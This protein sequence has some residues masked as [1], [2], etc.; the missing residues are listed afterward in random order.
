M[1][2][3]SDTVKSTVHFCTKGQIIKPI[4]LM[5]G[6]GWLLPVAV[7][8][9]DVGAQI[10][11]AAM[12]R[13]QHQITYDGRYLA[14]DYPGGDVPANIGVCTD[15]VIRTYRAIGVDLQVLVHEDMQAAFTAYPNHWGNRK[16]DANIDHRRVPN[17][18]TFFT[19]HGQSFAVRQADETV[20]AGDLIT[21]M[22]P[23]NLPHI[24]VVT[25]QRHPV[26]GR[27]MMVH[28]VGS[29]PKLEDVVQAWLI[30]GHYRFLPN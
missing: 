26:S 15:V 27:L 2:F 4:I 16:P 14:L 17:L 10:S 22:L 8:A 13:T 19:R 7:M 21:W 6:F 29:G 23:G 1:N 25:D 30:T 18:Q 11:V 24:G 5:I 12:E 3:I 9:N 20:Q 28:N